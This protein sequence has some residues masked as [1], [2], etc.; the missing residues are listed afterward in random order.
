MLTATTS[1]LFHPMIIL[2]FVVTKILL[3]DWNHMIFTQ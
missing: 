2:K 1:Q 3:Q